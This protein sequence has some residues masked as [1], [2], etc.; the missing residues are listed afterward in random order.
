MSHILSLALHVI[1]RSPCRLQPDD[2]VQVLMAG[3]TPSLKR[4]PNTDGAAPGP[5]AAL[6]KRG[7]ENMTAM[8]KQI[9]F[10][11]V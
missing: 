3:K 10:E 2:T 11:K 8:E 1:G 9:W 5:G 4:S 6:K 7:L